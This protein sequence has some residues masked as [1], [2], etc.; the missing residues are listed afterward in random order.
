[1]RTYFRD[2]PSATG[3]TP[4]IRDTTIFHK[5]ILLRIFIACYIIVAAVS[6]TFGPLPLPFLLQV[7]VSPTQVQGPRSF[8]LKPDS[9]VVLY[10]FVAVTTGR[11]PFCVAYL[12]MLSGRQTCPVCSEWLP[13]TNATQY[14]LNY[15]VLN[16]LAVLKQRAR[17]LQAYFSG[18]EQRLPI[19]G[20]ATSMPDGQSEIPVRAGDGLLASLLSAF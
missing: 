5:F 10:L 16:A 11:G 14:P 4:H 7:V 3:S 12:Q 8:I 20:Y 13:L 6:H 19:H 2:L 1:V 15:S 17:H 9:E 18:D